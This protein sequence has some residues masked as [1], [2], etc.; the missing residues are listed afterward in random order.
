MNNVAVLTFVFG[1][2]TD[3]PDM[4]RRQRNALPVGEMHQ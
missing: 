1:Y 3:W 4:V 2:S